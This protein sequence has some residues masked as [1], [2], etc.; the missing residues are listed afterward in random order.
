MERHLN[1]HFEKISSKLT[2]QSYSI[3]CMYAKPLFLVTLLTS[4]NNIFSV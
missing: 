1:W 4:V 3:G 2:V